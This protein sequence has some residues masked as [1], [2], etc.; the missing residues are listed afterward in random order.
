MIQGLLNEDRQRL[1]FALETG[2]IGIWDFDP[3][4]R[5][6]V[7]SGTCYAIFDIPAG[8]PI[9]VEQ[10]LRSVHPEDRINVA[11]LTETA[12]NTRHETEYNAVF[13]LARNAAGQIRWIKATGKVFVNEQERPVRFIGTALDITVQKEAE[14]LATQKNSELLDLLKEFTFVTD[15]MP[16]MVW[17][18]QADGYH[19]F[20]NK[21]WYDFTG[22]TYEE[23][24]DKGWALVLHPD[25]AERTWQVWK[26]SL[27]TG[28]LYQ[29]EYRMRRYDGEYRWF[30][31]RAMPLR[32]ENGI[33]LKWFG[34]CT[35]IHDQKAESQKLEQLVQERTQHLQQVNN[36]LKRSNEYLQ[37]FAYISSHDLKE[38]L[39]KIT[40]LGDLLASQY[41]QGLG[42]QGV[43]LL[44]RLQASTR[45]MNHLVQDLLTYSQ[46]TSAQ[47][48]FYPIDLNLLIQSVLTDLEKMIQE[49]GA[50]VKI[51]PL[52]QLP[53]D[54]MQLAQLWQNLLINAIKFRRPDVPP[55]VRVSSRRLPAGIYPADL[56][57]PLLNLP[58][59]PAVW[60]EISVQ[61]N[62][63]GFPAQ[64]KERIFQVFQQL[65]SRGQYE[66]TGVGLAIC[67]R[68]VE[69]HNGAIGVDTE[70]GAG[71]TFRI[72]LPT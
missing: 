35:D 53:G 50:Q 12:L 40:T 57:F 3:V 47:P 31:A 66:G 65:H 46:T 51:T 22:L 69:N 34:T 71:T 16:Q 30:L 58:D 17:A 60:W 27:E 20:Y 2:N 38:P 63:I 18:T 72:Y 24:K 67:R 64:Y 62:G 26:H 36:E 11:Q 25:D 23:T 7:W 8:T 33:I 15:F 14:E 10:Y 28:N 45:R 4:T 5:E 29:I 41:S 70:P 37:Q 49:T 42:E 39:R 32:D 19:D 61:D 43:D 6:G 59:S 44:R 1:E 54:P 9:T 68:V 56:A 55:R 48:S 13:R 21:R 52:P